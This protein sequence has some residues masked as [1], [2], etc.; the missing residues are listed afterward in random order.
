MAAYEPIEPIDVLARELGIPE[1]QIA[2]LDGN[3][4][5]YGP[6]PRALAALCSYPYYHIYSDPV[7]RDVRAAISRLL[8]LPPEHIVLGSGADEL[9]DIIGRMFVTPG[10]RVISAPPTFGMYSFIANLGGGEFF[11]I[12]RLSGFALDID[13]IEG[14][15]RS[16][17]ALIFLPSP[18]NPTGNSIRRTELDRLLATGAVVVI[19]EAY[20][21]F[22]GESFVQLVPERDNLIVLRTF[23][24]WA[25]LA[26]L[27]AGYGVFPAALAEL[28]RKIKMPYNLNVAAQVAIL[29]SLEDI[30]TLQERVALIVKER[31]RL[32]AELSAMPWL[33]PWPSETNFLLC[34]ISGIE[35]RDVWAELRAQGI[36]VRYF[37]TPQLRHC[38]RFTVGTPEHTNRLLRALE[39]IGERIGA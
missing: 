24:K 28:A 17:D 6:S 18:N 5:P 11:P 34:E 16:G 7:Q 22:G 36:L 29:A 4:N 23:S 3:E 33:S 9:L 32:Y 25:G 27:R 30:E 37:D 26:G 38:L 2:K 20:V 13:A 14:A 35:A 39:E 19:D 15:T 21:E 12:Q 31:E 8:H 1:D 10:S